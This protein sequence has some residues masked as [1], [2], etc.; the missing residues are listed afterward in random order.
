MSLKIEQRFDDVLFTES[1]PR[2]YT[3]GAHIVPMKI[4]IGQKQ[5]YVWVVDEFKDD[6]YDEDGK[7]CSPVVYSTKKKDLLSN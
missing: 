2:I 3:T 1:G 7:I 5:R 6:S 4:K